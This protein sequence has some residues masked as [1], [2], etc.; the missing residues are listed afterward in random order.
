MEVFRFMKN[1]AFMWLMVF[2]VAY[3]HSKQPTGTIQGKIID[4]ET[5]A[6]LIGT[7]VSL[8]GTVQGAASDMG[9]S[10]VISKVP[11]GS[12][13]LRFDYMGYEQFKKTDVIVRSERITFVNVELK[14]VAIE[15]DEVSVT[16]GYFSE[17]KEEP[18]S[19]INFSYEEIRRAP[20]SAGDVSR[21]LMTLPS[22]A[23]V[24]DQSNNLIVRGGNPIENTFY[25]DNIEIPNINHF[26]HQG[27]S[28]GPIGLLNVDFIQD[29]TFYSG[30]F[31]SMYG[32]KLS[33]IM[34]I[35]FREGNR[36]E[37]DGQLDL[38]FSGF[39]GV[40]E[41]PLFNGKGSWL[42]SGRRSYLDFVVDVFDVGST[43]APIYGDMQGKIVYE[44]N[45]SHKLMLLGVF[46]DDHNAPD[47]KT[48]QE[49]YMTHYGNQDLYQ[50]T[51]GL[52][53]RAIWGKSGYSNTSL[54]YTSNKYDEDWYETTTGIYE[55]RNRTGE[56]ALKLRNINHFRLNKNNSFEFG[57]E[58]KKLIEDYDNWYAESTNDI[59]EPVPALTLKN[60]ITGNKIGGF[61][62]YILNPFTRLTT[63]LGLRADYFSFNENLVASPR[64]AFS[65]Q[66]TH[67]FSLNGS[68]G[69]FYQNLPLLLLVQNITNKNM[70]TPK[71][72]HYVLG[73]NHLLTNN[74]RLTLEVYQ[75]NYKNFPID[76]LQPELFIIDGSYFNNYGELA[77]NGEALS[78]GVE[79]MIQ[80]KLA[81][82]FYGL[83]SASF[84]RSRYKG[85]DDVW[86]DRNFDNRVTFSLE[87]GYKPNNKWEFSMRWIFAGGVPYTPFN[88]EESKVLHRAVYDKNKINQVRYPDYHSMNI[89]FD[90][91][92]NFSRSNVVFYLSVWNTY[93]RKNIANYFWNDK[94]QKQDEVFQWGLLP[95]FG[96]EYEF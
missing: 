54:A 94:D 74:T 63:T 41:G 68:A 65:Y 66:L 24:N 38:N 36:D 37:F 25:I 7:N 59:G 18:T 22:I 34:D 81:K 19:V 95:I 26:P 64:F 48:G 44:I 20:G 21:I 70:A 10:F 1:M 8:V 50:A 4:A 49:N 23:K 14:M 82:N 60:E 92:F 35:S 77:D 69:I 29:V 90:R 62:N 78:R 5:K 56:Q 9:G 27:A 76:P 87:G 2:Y 55:I 83:A 47:R 75:K 42:F 85:G 12:Y 96:V 31:S 28:G 91:R 33:S 58:A 51:T 52:N 79:L 72:I 30:G 3:G 17:S 86:R 93:N 43:V 89:R 80:K 13:V 88:V 16:A 15:T 67:K 40:A 71:A 84:F 6:P 46:A 61:I 11:V 53:W 45:Q 73:I 57:I 32:D 39:G